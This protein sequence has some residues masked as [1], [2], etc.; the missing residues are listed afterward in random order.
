MARYLTT[1]TTSVLLGKTDRQVRRYCEKGFFVYKKEG[2]Q[3]LVDADSVKAFLQKNI[4]SDG[5]VSFFV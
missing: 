5:S 4:A 1:E 3:L 2:K